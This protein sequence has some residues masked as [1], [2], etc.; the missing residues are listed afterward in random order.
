MLLPQRPHY[1]INV[2]LNKLIELVQREINTVIGHPPLREVVS[3][4][5]LRAITTAYQIAPL[6]G[7]RLLLLALANIVDARRQQRHGPCAVFVL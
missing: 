3:A 1:L 6:I 5:P 7:L 2:A 4:N